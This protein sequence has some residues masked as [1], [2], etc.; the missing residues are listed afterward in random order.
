MDTLT[1]FSTGVADGSGVAS[2]LGLGFAF[3]EVSEG[4]AES[5]VEEKGAEEADHASR[6]TRTPLRSLRTV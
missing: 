5:V 1:A 2:E 3:S 6:H 4:F